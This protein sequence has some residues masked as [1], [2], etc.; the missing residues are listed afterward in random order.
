MEE[1]VSNF[2]FSIFVNRVIEELRPEYGIV[3]SRLRNSKVSLLANR[4][5]GFKH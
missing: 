5:G 1:G 2:R 4:S 3:P